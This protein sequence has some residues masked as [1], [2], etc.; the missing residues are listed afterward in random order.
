[1][2][3]K[4]QTVYC[5]SLFLL[6]WPNTGPS[7][8]GT[9]RGQVTWLTGYSSSSRQNPGAGTEAEAVE[10]CS[11]ACSSSLAQFVPFRQCSEP[12]ESALHRQWTWVLPRQSLTKKCPYRHDLRPIWVTN[13]QNLAITSSSWSST[14]RF[15]LFKFSS[16]S[17]GQLQFPY[18]VYFSTLLFHLLTYLILRRPLPYWLFWQCLLQLF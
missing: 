12:P 7:S 4:K 5:S 2:K 13:W 6:L 15:I 9:W 16:I 11:W 14:C 17:L 8:R 3:I 10:K 18:F 1:M